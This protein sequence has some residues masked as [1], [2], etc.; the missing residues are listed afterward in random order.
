MRR[1]ELISAASAASHVQER[2]NGQQHNTTMV[3]TRRAAATPARCA[4]DRRAVL[5][6]FHTGRSMNSND[7][8]LRP[9]CQD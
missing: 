1:P 6:R 8:S 5:R 3:V 9:V 2:I 7:E 4:L